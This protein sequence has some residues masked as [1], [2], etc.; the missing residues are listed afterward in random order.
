MRALARGSTGTKNFN[1]S[2]I[3]PAIFAPRNRIV[4]KDSSHRI[5][6]LHLVFAYVRNDST[7]PKIDIVSKITR[8]LKDENFI[9]PDGLSK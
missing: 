9:I 2:F 1:A 4:Y 5:F 6:P 8:H 3:T 7:V